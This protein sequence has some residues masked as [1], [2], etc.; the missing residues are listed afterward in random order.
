[1][2]S[3]RVYVYPGVYYINTIWIMYGESQANLSV[4]RLSVKL[5]SNY[6]IKEVRLDSHGAE[7]H[8]IHSEKLVRQ[9][10]PKI[11]TRRL[12]TRGQS[13]Y[14]YYGVGIKKSS[15]YFADEKQVQNQNKIQNRVI[16][17]DKVRNIKS[18]KMSGNVRKSVVRALKTATQVMPQLVSI[19]PHLRH[20]PRASD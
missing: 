18:S 12:G 8:F 14:H 6:E 13:K 15:I 3:K 17:K 2:R 10:F 5:D 9:K 16:S 4:P 11:T 19:K 20:F 7:S 1:M